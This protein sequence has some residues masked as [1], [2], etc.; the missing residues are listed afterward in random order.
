[1]DQLERYEQQLEEDYE[2]GVISGK[3]FD[4]E[5]RELHRDYRAAAEEQA[6]Q[7]YDDIMGRW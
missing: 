1:M 2:T 5:M 6:Q 3:E 4:Q 7:A